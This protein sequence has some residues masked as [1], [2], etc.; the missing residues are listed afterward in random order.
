MWPEDVHGVRAD[1][2]AQ[3]PSGIQLKYR[4]WPAS[5]I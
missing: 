3:V 4:A 5:I 1:N 2:K